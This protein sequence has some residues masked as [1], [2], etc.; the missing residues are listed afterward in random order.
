MISRIWDE[1]V[2]SFSLSSN[3]SSG[4]NGS[5]LLQAGDHCRKTTSFLEFAKPFFDAKASNS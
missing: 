2:T 1:A 3:F 5:V 4:E